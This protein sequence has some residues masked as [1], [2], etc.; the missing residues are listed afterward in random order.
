MGDHLFFLLKKLLVKVN[1]KI[2]F[3]ELKLQLLSHPSYPSLHAVTGVLNH[4]E[5]ENMALEVPQNRET[6]QQLPTYFLA[7]LETKQ[8][9]L[10]KKMKNSIELTFE[11]ESRKTFEIDKFLSVWSGVIV[12]VDEE[13]VEPNYDNYRNEGVSKALQTLCLLVV[14]GFFF[15]IR[16]TLFESVYFILSLAGIW[17]SILILK[18]E[19]GFYSKTVEK[20]CTAAPS[21]N[22]DDVLNSKGASFLGLFKLSDISLIYFSA[23]AIGALIATLASI[24]Y[25]AFVTI[26]L[27]AL[28]ITIYSIYYQYQI[29]KKWCPLC[30]TIVSVLWLQAGSLFLRSSSIITLKFDISSNFI[31][32]FSLIL[33]GSIWLFIRPLLKK[34]HA[35]NKLEVDHYKFKRN[36]ELFKAALS[37]SDSLDMHIPKTNEIVLGKKNAPLKLLLV[38]SPS[39]YYCKEAHLDLEKIL[40][41]HSNEVNVTIR[42]NVPEDTTQI[43]NKVA[44]RLLEIYKMGDLEKIEHSLHSAYEE[45][46]D[47]EKWIEI[48]EESKTSFE[49]ILKTQKAWC[50]DNHVNFTPALYVNGKFFPKVYDRSDLSYFI[51]DLTEQIDVIEPAFN[52][53]TIN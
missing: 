49:S 20:F 38:T 25:D 24:T 3:D 36:V 13:N 27:L 17:V 23:L 16:P 18:Q 39:C 30:L 31:L 41:K 29:V 19:L 14:V 40:R 34:Q 51:E 45:N 32:F 48:N 8:F 9:V 33:F 37:N 2:N 12:V 50:N 42:F 47:L 44:Q 43:A 22:C 1:H 6:L 10:I 4:F 21:S 26:S 35:Y 53:E 52:L 7:F 5:I 15:Y 46:V 28:P 11:D